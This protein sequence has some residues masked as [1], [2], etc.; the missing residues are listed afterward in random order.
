M[1]SIRVKRAFTLIELIIVLIL[2]FSTYFIIFSNNSFK[3]SEKKEPLTLEN[4][5]EQLLKNIQFEKELKFFCIEDDLSCYV[6]VDGIVNEKTKIK[7]FFSQRPDIYE[8]NNSKIRLEYFDEKI[9][10]NSKDVFFEFIIDSDYKTNDF[11]LE[12]LEEK[13]YVFN[14]IYEKPILYKNL[15]DAFDLF[16]DNETEVRDAF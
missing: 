7:N 12:Y 11:I 13:V 3:I 1:R 2:V 16:L 15:N 10:D 5:K 6:K 14:S 9:E 4:L 8:Y